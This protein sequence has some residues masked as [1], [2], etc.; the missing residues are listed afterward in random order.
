MKLQ[1][2]Y[3]ILFYKA[4]SGCNSLSLAE[5]RVRDYFMESLVKEVNTFQADRK[6]IIEN[7]CIKDESGN[8]E[9]LNNIEY[10]FTPENGA[11]FTEEEALLLEEEST[12][13][14]MEKL[15]DILEK[16]DYKPAKGEAREIDIIISCIKGTP[17]PYGGELENKTEETADTTTEEGS[18]GVSG[19][20]V[21]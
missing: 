11:K 4:L 3:L 10:Q 18:E 5:A 15:A 7:L 13:V 1:K 8:P 16:T 17:S 9:M 6:K 2:K 19:E 21:E 12:M 20:S 14:G